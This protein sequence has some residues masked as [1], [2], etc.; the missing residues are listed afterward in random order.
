MAVLT[1][2]GLGNGQIQ[3][4]FGSPFLFTGGGDTGFTAS[5]SY[6]TVSVTGTGLTYSSSVLNGQ[7]V[8]QLTGGTITG[9]SYTNGPNSQTW[10]NI[11][12][13]AAAAFNAILNFNAF[14][15]LFFNGDDVFTW[16]AANV[17]GNAPFLYGYGGKIG[18]AH[19]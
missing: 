3:A 6:G 16:N 2:T 10:S 8:Y 17:S 11:S 4:V 15:S 5:N 14:N 7:T 13:S 19:V 9:V 12:V 1:G 18:R